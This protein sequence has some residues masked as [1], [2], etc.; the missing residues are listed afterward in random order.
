MMG[1]SELFSGSGGI[2]GDF[3]KMLAT[4]GVIGAFVVMFLVWGSM[5]TIGIVLIVA[6]LGGG[7]AL[8]WYF[9]NGM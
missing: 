6:V 9:K 8:W 2:G 7:A 5:G 4:L 1:L 3:M